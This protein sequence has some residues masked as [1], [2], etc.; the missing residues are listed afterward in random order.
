[1][2]ALRL[3]GCYLS[4]DDVTALLR[5]RKI[6][7]RS[8]NLVD[9][10]DLYQIL[11][12]TTPRVTGYNTGGGQTPYGSSMN[13]SGRFNAMSVGGGGGAGSTPWNPA[14]SAVY[15]NSPFVGGGANAP[16]NLGQTWPP[17]GGGAG[18]TPWQTPFNPNMTLGGSAA[19]GGYGTSGDYMLQ[20]SSFRRECNPTNTYTSALRTSRSSSATPCGS[21]FRSGGP[22]CPYTGSSRRPTKTGGATSRSNP[23]SWC[24]SSSASRSR[25]WRSA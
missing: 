13:M 11:L 20:V 21:A 18:G 14:A 8:D 25:P 6:R 15:P 9:V 2:N 5:A 4:D 17:P 10:N 12:Q 3:A 19:L 24:S 7:K 23:S 16:M 22:A 1:M